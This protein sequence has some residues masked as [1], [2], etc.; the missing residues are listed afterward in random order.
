MINTVAAVQSIEFYD[1]LGKLLR[2]EDMTKYEHGKTIS[3]RNMSAGLYFLK[4]NIADTEFIK[5]L[6][7]TK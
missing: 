7:V 1:V 2:A 4:V 3:V 6:I 5:K